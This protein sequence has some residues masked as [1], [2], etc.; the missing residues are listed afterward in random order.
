MKIDRFEL[1][2]NTGMVGIFCSLPLSFWFLLIPF[3]NRTR[4]CISLI[5]TSVCIVSNR[6]KV[7]A[8]F[9]FFFADAI[10]IIR[11]YSDMQSLRYKWNDLSQLFKLSFRHNSGVMCKTLLGFAFMFFFSFFHFNYSP[12]QGV[13]GL[14]GQGPTIARICNSY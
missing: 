9:F 2:M 13:S 8:S 3:I 10:L 4:K 11:Q 12:E 7:H 5:P 6:A 14:Q 1:L